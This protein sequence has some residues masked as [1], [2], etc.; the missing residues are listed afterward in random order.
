MKIVTGNA[1]LTCTFENMR[2]TADRK[3]P[4]IDTGVPVGFLFPRL[5]EGSKGRRASRDRI[6]ASRQRS[7]KLARDVSTGRLAVIFNEVEYYQRRERV[8]KRTLVTPRVRMGQ[9]S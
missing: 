5:C 6:I 4:P 1:Y 7:R 9:R 8:A 2:R 3:K